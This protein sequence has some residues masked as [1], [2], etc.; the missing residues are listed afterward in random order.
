MLDFLSL[1]RFRGCD[2]RCA[3]SQEGPEIFA[4]YPGKFLGIAAGSVLAPGHLFMGAYGGYQVAKELGSI[5]GKKVNAQFMNGLL[6]PSQGA[7]ML[8]QA[9]QRANNTGLINDPLL[10]RASIL[11]PY[12][13]ASQNGQAP[14]R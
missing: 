3:N 7:D 2:T 12:L 14:G 8:S 5:A 13:S 4:T 11:A 9:L 1:A 10:N 6:N